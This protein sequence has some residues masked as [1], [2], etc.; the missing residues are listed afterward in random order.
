MRGSTRST[1]AQVSVS[2]GDSVTVYHG[3]GAAMCDSAY[4][5]TTGWDASKTGTANNVL[6]ANTPCN[7]DICCTYIFC[8]DYESCSQANYRI[9]VDIAYVPSPTPAPTAGATA[10]C[11]GTKFLPAR[12]R[13]ENVLAVS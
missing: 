3:S 1:V 10:A 7:D 12:A 5:P 2:G 4:L 13:S 8:E 6:L 11:D 9:V